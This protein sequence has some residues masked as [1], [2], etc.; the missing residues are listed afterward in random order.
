VGPGVDITTLDNS[1]I[2][3]N[4]AW[5]A[6]PTGVTYGLGDRGTPGTGTYTQS[7]PAGPV[8]TVT[9]PAATV[10]IGGTR[11]LSAVAKDADGHTASTTFTWG[12]SDPTVATV[13]ATGVAHG[14]VEGSVTIT[15][16]A[17]NG[18]SGTGTLTVT[19][20]VP[21]SLS[22]H[23]DAPHQVPVGYVKPAFIDFVQ[24]ANGNDI[25]PIPPITWS[26]SAPSIATIDQDGYITGVGVGTTFITAQT[27]NGV[28]KTLSFDIIAADA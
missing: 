25:S 23:T 7:A 8:T 2:A 1:T 13:A 12:S 24:D 3:G 18:V 5:Q 21:A 10:T 4:T 27:A 19:Q 17:A 14:L 26:S 20:P 28:S 15:V 6:T 22:W 11:Q 9:V 16:T